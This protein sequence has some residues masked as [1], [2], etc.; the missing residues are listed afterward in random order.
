MGATIAFFLSSS[1]LPLRS[2]YLFVLSFSSDSVIVQLIG[3][4]K[5]CLLALFHSNAW[6]QISL[7]LFSK[8]RL[9]M[10]GY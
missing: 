8:N 3:R 9:D 4:K 7:G 2:F 10:Y 1:F 6:L 5:T